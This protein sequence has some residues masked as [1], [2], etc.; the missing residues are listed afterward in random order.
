VGRPRSGRPLAVA[1]RDDGH[2][3]RAVGPPGGGRAAQ[4]GGARPLGRSPLMPPKR[5]YPAP[6][7]PTAAHSQ[8]GLQ[9]PPRRRR[10]VPFGSPTPYTRGGPLVAVPRPHSMASSTEPTISMIP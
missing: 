8:Q 3:H 10:S 7:D 1:A 2:R 6:T 4:H 5:A 9:H